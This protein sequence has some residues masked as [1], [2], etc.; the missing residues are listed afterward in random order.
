V[1]G[2]KSTVYRRLLHAFH[3]SGLDP[4]ILNVA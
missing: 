1:L 3:T 4:A 2:L